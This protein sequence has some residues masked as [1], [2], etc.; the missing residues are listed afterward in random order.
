M[1]LYSNTLA[2]FK[3]DHTQF[4][5]SEAVSASYEKAFHRKASPS[6]IKSW[7]NSL[8]NMYQV[9]HN[10]EAADDCGILIE[11]NLPNTSRRID[12][13]I[14]GEDRQ[15]HK[16]LV[17][18]ELKQWNSAE[19]TPMD[20]VVKTAL[21][22]GV[23]NTSHPSYQAYGYKRFLSD[24]NEEVYSGNIDAKAC[25]FL[26]NY[27]AQDPEPLISDHYRRYLQEAP[28][29]FR[30]D[31]AKLEAFISTHVGHGKGMDILY[32]IENGKIRPSVKLI[33]AVGSLFKKNL[34]FTLLDEQKV[35]YET[36]L[37]KPLK[38][39]KQVVIIQ[40]G[41]G[42]GKSV[43]SFNLLYGLLKKKR[44]A[45]LAAP[46]AAFREVMKRRLQRSGLKKKSRNPD[47]QFILNTII[48]GSAGFFK[49]SSNT[50][51]TVIV[52]EAHRLKNGTA[53]QYQGENQIEDI[54]RSAR[55][56]L[57]FIDDYQAI[58][59]EDIG[60]CTNIK[61]VAAHCQAEVE[62]FT[63]DVQFRCA[64]MDG[65][66]NWVDHTLQIRDTANFSS[67]D[68]AAYEVE[69]C[70]SPQAVYS[71][72]LQEVSHGN[73]ARML[74]GYAWKWTSKKQ[75]N[76]QGQI[77]DVSIPE[78]DF[79]LPWNSRSASSTW[80]IDPSGQGQVGC[81]H[82]SQGLEFDYVGILIGRDLQYDP[83]KRILHA[84][85]AE[86]KDN[87]GKRG[88]K[89]D[90]EALTRLVKNI[91]KTL[92]TRAQRGCFIYCCDPN[93]QEYLKACLPADEAVYSLA[94]DDFWAAE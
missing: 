92:M 25:A 66:I 61:S 60:S 36:L 68:Q 67:W 40:G 75:G 52:D 47:D 24:F 90:P 59:P 44:H 49:T 85:W 28:L 10:A 93:L 43:L 45:V 62:E 53:Y 79:A 64:G 2:K 26:H 73:S 32:A 13:I 33:D 31:H 76:A 42:T 20:G 27:Q 78:H 11:Y 23:R 83:E 46:N 3:A 74:A 30:K 39:T 41:P 22:G 9:V 89:N 18:V 15:K 38:E 81:I 5:L 91:Y 34:F 84:S 77:A 12:F 72:I 17:I 37:T 54:I 57:F 48:T 80:A 4:Q 1:I 7:Q 70:D 6:E 86:Y 82:T 56:S 58:R 8:G 88:L 19:A 16:N 87:T 55:T 29:Y 63:L 21:G 35:L 50:Y 51:D 71:K 94:R 69:I 14:T 65:Y